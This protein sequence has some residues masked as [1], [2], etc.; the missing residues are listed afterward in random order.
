[1]TKKYNNI[2]LLLNGELPSSSLLIKKIKD[3]DF[4]I[5]VDGA[6]NKLD[7]FNIKPNVIIGDFDSINKLDIKS[8]K[9]INTPD[10][11]K[12]D[13]KKSLE[14][15]VKQKL[16]EVN[17]FGLSGKS[18]DHFLGN[19]Y[20]CNEFS[21]LLKLKAFTDRSI[22]TPCIGKNKFNSFKNQKVSLFVLENSSIVTSINLEFVLKNFELFPTND[23]IRNISMG[24]TFCIESSSKILVFQSVN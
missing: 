23:A 13:F 7:Q 16:T 12:T 17:I 1:M 3:S 18:D 4:I 14:W 22:I 21:H 10:Q 6:A 24:D 11:S 20:T 9:Y 8:A 5:A 15:I 19:L 2:A